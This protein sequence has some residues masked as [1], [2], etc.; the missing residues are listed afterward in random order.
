MKDFLTKYNLFPVFEIYTRGDKAKKPKVKWSEKENLIYDAENLTKEGYGLIC[1]EKSGI[2]VLDI[3]GDLEMLNRLCQAAEVEKEEIEKTLWIKTANGGYHIYFKYQPGLTNKAKIFEDCDIRTE[4]GYVVAPLSTIQNKKGKLV[5]YEPLNNNPIQSIPQKLY[6]FIRYGEI[7]LENIEKIEIEE[8]DYD[9]A[10]ETMRGMREGDGRNNALNK[11]LYCWAMHEHIEDLETIKEKAKYINNEIFAEPEPGALRTAESVYKAVLRK[12]K[13]NNQII[14]EEENVYY[15]EIKQNGKIIKVPISN[16][17][18]NPIRLIECEEDHNLDVLEAELKTQNGEII[19]RTYPPNAFD[20][21]DKF[22]ATTNSLAIRFTGTQ[23]DLQ[24]IKTDIYNRIP[25]K[26]RGVLANGLYKIEG[27]WAFV[28]RNGALMPNN[29]IKKDIVQIMLDGI[30][31]NILNL[32]PINRR[33][34]Q[35]IAPLLFSFNSIEISASIMG[36]MGCLFLKERLRQE[37]NI[38]LPHLLIAGEAGAGKSETVERIIMTMLSYN[39]TRTD[40]S[41]VTAYA[42]EKMLSSSNTLP[43]IIDEYKPLKMTSYQVNL[44]SKLLRNSYDGQ[45]AIRGQKDLTLQELTLLAPIILIGEL[46]TRETAVIER[47][48]ILTFSKMESYP[49]FENFNKLI[50]SNLLS[51]LGRS[52]LNQALKISKE[53]LRELLTKIDEN[54]IES[55]IVPRILNIIK[56]VMLGLYMIKR[57]FEEKGLDFEKETG[58]NLD[59]I[60]EKLYENVIKEN[61]DGLMKTKT[62]IDTTLEFISQALGKIEIDDN[63][64]LLIIPYKTRD[65]VGMRLDAVYTETYKFLKNHGYPINSIMEKQDFKK[66]L[67]KTEYCEGERIMVYIDENGKKKSARCIVI[68]LQKAEYNSVEVEGIRKFIEKTE[69]RN[70]VPQEEKKFEF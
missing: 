22:N 7:S 2:M 39:S 37:F 6:N 40:A 18:I 25:E 64:P 68:D 58:Q 66:Q 20:K 4:G 38:K 24:F 31:S 49:R 70:I 3:D 63:L 19:K 16:F 48:L 57:V 65:K 12:R 45:N 62:L 43:F 23:K 61:L 9:K 29:F 46:S 50:H 11:F 69:G 13:E 21:I 55:G 36:Y 1:G 67:E 17:I 35:I 56:C 32:E 27:Q 41:G 15:K 30:H 28:D 33:E 42:A 5:K 34:L 51:K 52:L 10:I 60:Q 44:I 53:E 47:S 14:V 8:F 54:L 59:E 26:I